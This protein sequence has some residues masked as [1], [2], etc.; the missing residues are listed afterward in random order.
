MK[1]IVLTLALLLC[2]V[3]NVLAYSL[4]TATASAHY[5]H[6]VLKVIEDKGN[7]IGIGQG[8]CDN[9]VHPQALFEEVDG[10]LYLAFRFNL[11]DNIESVNFAVQK[12]GD[13]DFVQVDHELIAETTTTRDYR[14]KVPSKDVIVRSEAFITAMGRAVI[15]YMDF[16][17]FVEGNT[18]FIALGEGGKSTLEKS[19][20]NGDNL[21]LD[22]VDKAM[23]SVGLGYD[24]GLLMR[25]SA[26]L[27]RLESFS[28][29]HKSILGDDEEDAND[30]TDL[31]EGRSTAKSN[32]K[33]SLGASSR[34]VLNG[35]IF[36]LVLITFFFLATAFIL[37]FVSKY[38]KELNEAREEA[39]YE[40]D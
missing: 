1:K 3:P 20:E 7:N 9:V 40:E 34:A 4:E 2:F 23:S 24:H 17:D 6:P 36:M 28:G 27:A 39:L 5:E 15:F 38:L 31:G 22:A 35:L 13:E 37:Y 25:G 21:S 8:M 12:A 30:K 16:A 10:E 29:G 33:T 11:A 32:K 26:E 14:I 19:Y 18:D